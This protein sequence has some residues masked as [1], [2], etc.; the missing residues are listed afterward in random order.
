MKAYKHLVKQLL[1][2]NFTMSVYS[3]GTS[4]D[5]YKSNNFNDIIEAIEA[6]DEASLRIRDKNNNSFA[7][8]LIIY[9]LSDDETV[10]DWSAANEIADNWLETWYNA[11]IKEFQ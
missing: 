7:N 8:V 11:Y 3:G 2:E 9:G 10:A 6:V 1:K 4:L 5:L